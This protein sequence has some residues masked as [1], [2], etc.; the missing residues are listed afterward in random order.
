[1]VDESLKIKN[2]APLVGAWIETRLS[3]LFTEEMMV[4]PLVGAWIETKE[5]E[6]P[7]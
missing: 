3:P 6:A 1:M 7:R 2:V 4:A 5:R